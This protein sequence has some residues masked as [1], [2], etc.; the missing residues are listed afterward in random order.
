MYPLIFQEDS[1]G[2]PL[3]GGFMVLVRR[4][5]LKKAFWLVAFCCLV[6]ASV[7]SAYAQTVNIP[8]SL[9]AKMLTSLLVESTFQGEGESADV[10]GAPGDCIHVR[11]AEPHYRI[12][13]ERLRLQLSLKLH[14]GTELGGKC[15]FP[16]EWQGYLVLW[17]QPLFRSSQFGL[18]FQVL[19][20]QLLGSDG[21]PAAI[22]GIVWDLVKDRV[23]Q[24][25]ERVEV[26]LA[27]PVDNLRHFLAP[28]FRPEVREATT[29]M[30]NSMHR[31]QVLVGDGK[32]TVELLAEVEE[33]F[34]PARDLVPLSDVERKELISLWERWDSF[35]VYILTMVAS[36]PLESGDRQLL[37]DT[38]L[39]SRYAFAAA[40]EDPD[41]KEDLVRSQFLETWKGLAPLFRRRLYAS[42]AGNNTLGFLA[43][44]T[45]ADALTLFDSM[46]PTFGIELSEQG[47]LYLAEMLSGKETPLPY[48]LDINEQLRTIFE[49]QP[50]E[51]TD[52]PERGLE[53]IDLPPETD[54]GPLSFFFDFMVTPACGET[55]AKLPG[56]SEILKWKV[57]PKPYPE[58]VGR[59]R[60][61]LDR[62]AQKTLAKGKIPQPLKNIYIDMIPAIAWQESCFRQF[63]VRNKKL[64]YLLSY[65]NSSVGVMQINERIWRGLFNRDRLR[66]DIDYN[67][68]AGCEIVSIYLN[69]YVLRD[70]GWSKGDKPKL[71]ARLIYSM[72]NGGPGQYKKFLQREKSGKHYDSDKLFAQKLKWTMNKDW[73]KINRC[74]IGG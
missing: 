60:A 49:L 17:Q 32:L 38:L 65:N 27:P 9:D 2:C 56:F 16:V 68:A 14:G 20:S 12:E 44:F 39:T 69:R 8:L 71:L 4:R 35:L 36:G 52:M 48:L 6:F 26:D 19:D 24:H 42:P 25:L 57:P 41:S 11:L 46:G 3:Q 33:R 1:K 30:L 63:V 22:A 70:K 13:G 58:Y 47:L 37:V 15:M 67:A 66:W 10:I 72:Y 34:E 55:T 31:G 62:A 74:L 23:Y 43:F 7:T 18:S 51:P 40:L 50:E 61:V 73:K 59:V 29:A 45:A 28:L 21:E 5:V 54:E 53:E 64:T